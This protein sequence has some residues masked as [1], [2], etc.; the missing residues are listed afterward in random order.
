[1]RRITMP[2]RVS[3]SRA[4]GPLDVGPTAVADAPCPPTL[5]S[6][7]CGVEPAAE[8]SWCWLWRDV[9]K[10]VRRSCGAAFQVVLQLSAE[11]RT[12]DDSRSASSCVDDCTMAGLVDG[13]LVDAEL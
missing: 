1:M 3:T 7:P 2:C 11:Q 13:I 10:A 4:L 9:G 6:H 12:A 5:R 8:Q